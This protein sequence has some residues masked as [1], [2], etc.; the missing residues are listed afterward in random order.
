MSYLLKNKYGKIITNKAVSRKYENACIWI[1]NRY[2]KRMDWRFISHMILFISHMILHMFHCHSPKSSHPH[3]L[4]QSPKDCSIYLCLFC[5]LTYRDNR[6]CD[7]WM[8][9]LT[10]WM[11]IW[12]NSGSWWWTGRPGMLRFMGSQRV[13]HNWATDLIW[14]RWMKLEPIIQ[15]EI[16][17]KEKHQYSIITQIYGI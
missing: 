16:S 12:V 4:P 15:S 2:L 9:S 6:G 5:C 7:G 10:G 13:G 14:L 3:P 8:A 11:W 1:R 17:Q